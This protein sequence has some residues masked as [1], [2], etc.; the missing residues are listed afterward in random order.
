MKGFREQQAPSRKE[1]IR[2]METELKNVQMALRISQ[3]MMQQMMQSH[4]GVTEDLGKALGLINE[5]QYKVLAVQSVGALDLTA[6]NA[7]AD[8]LRLKDFNEAS[9]RE[10]KENNFAVG[11]AVN[12]DSIIIVTTKTEETDKGIFRSKFKLA[13]CGAPDLIEGFMG[14]EVGAKGVVKL[15]GLDH[16]IELLGIRQPP[17]AEAAPAEEAPALTVV[18]NV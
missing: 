9:D 10:D 4:K 15:N 16:E 18:G 12:E 5:L 1:R 2:E 6:L 8:E 13:E 3:M 7:K 17:K 11:N 14:R